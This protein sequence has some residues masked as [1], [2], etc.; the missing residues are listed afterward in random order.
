MT[1][2]ARLALQLSWFVDYVPAW[3]GPALIAVGLLSVLF[4]FGVFVTAGRD[5]QSVTLGGLVVLSGIVGGGLLIVPLYVRHT[6]V[7]AAGMLLAGRWLEGVAAT[8]VLTKAIRFFSGTGSGGLASALRRRLRRGAIVFGL[9]LVA[10]WAA[11][12]VLVFGPVALSRTYELTLIWT[13]LVGV[14]SF[15]GLGFKF[16][17]VDSRV[18]SAVPTF[19]PMVLGLILAVT[20]AQLYNFQILQRTIS[21]APVELSFS[22]VDPVLAVAGNGVYLAGY[23]WSVRRRLREIG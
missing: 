22:A 5:S 9:L 6:S 23:Y 16:T 19:V 4:T 2:V 13:V 7:V 1:P 14:L 17:S 15:L 21:T 3:L 20:G 10:G 12:W 11:I 8:R 18:Y